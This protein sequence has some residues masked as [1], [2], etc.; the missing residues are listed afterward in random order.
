MKIS[1]RCDVF[2][3]FNMTHAINEGASQIIRH[4]AL[5][6]ITAGQPPMTFG[7]TAALAGTDR[8]AG[9]IFVGPFTCMFASN[10]YSRAWQN[11]EK[12]APGTAAPCEGKLQNTPVYNRILIALSF[13][14]ECFF[15]L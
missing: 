11:L 15:S 10:A 5:T 6:S 1:G 14:Q 7:R 12:D 4:H 3:K 9:A 8:V 13:V 2:A